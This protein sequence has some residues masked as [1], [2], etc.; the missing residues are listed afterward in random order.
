MAVL[1]T[2]RVKFGIAIT[3]IIALAL[4]SFIVDPNTL[5]S[6]SQAMS[7]KYDVGKING[8]TVSYQDF[9]ADVDTYTVISELMTGSS[10]RGDQ[11]TKEIRNQAWQALIDK[12]LFI[13]NA[14]A[15]GI[16]VGEQELIDLTTGANVSP[17]IAQNFMDEN[18]NFSKEYLVQFVQ[19]AKDDETG[20]LNTLWNYMQNVIRTQQYYTKY[21]ALFANSNVQSPLMLAKLIEE[22]NVSSNVDFVMVPTSF[23]ADSV[24]NVS[25]NEIK[26]YYNAHKDFFKQNA[27]RDIEYVLFQVTPSAKDVAE[28]KDAYLALYEEFTTTDNMKS[29]LLRNSD[30]P[31]S[32]YWYSAGELNTVNA[33]INEFVFSGAEGSSEMVQDG[34]TFYAARIMASKMIPDEIEVRYAPGSEMNDST[35]A[36]LRDAEPMTMTQSYMVP[37]F[38]PLFEAKVGTP[39]VVD[40]PSYGKF[41]AELVSSSE[42]VLK[43]QV[44]IY[45][46]AALPSKETY[47]NSYS[48][49]NALAVQSAGKLENFQAAVEEL[50]L[51]SHPVNRMTEASETLGGVE[52]TKEITRWAFDQKKAGKV[53]DIITIN[54][55]YFFVVACTGIH[56]EGYAPVEEAA[57]TIKSSLKADKVAEIQKA[58]IAK[59]I[60]GLNSLESIAEALGTTVSHSDDITFSSLM[61]Q[62]SDPAF[63]GAV[64]AAETGKI[65]GPVAGTYGV[66]VF[67]VNSR[68]T[69]SYFTEDDAK[70]S[71]MQLAQR[72]AQMLMYVM[73]DDADVKDNRARFF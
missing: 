15:A 61:S 59:K 25:S 71:E 51:V 27:S 20:R 10:V 37:G 21:A 70:A 32:N 7:S 53:S 4:L 49:A 8:K 46:K 58:E 45:E 19:S 12:Y 24:A 42:P 6:V 29:F 23:V 73:M 67:R 39:I 22:N 48:E 69:G 64:S 17:I 60:S 54:Q 40:V 68:E 57:A 11:E 3:V 41:L 55:N 2:I 44:A 50:G 63:V 28:A 38:E 65:T 13:K 14:N 31:L 35:L 36:V 62:G 72:N 9:Q 43:K 18:G 66:Y 26:N 47:N 30:R 33:A 52:N 56:K 1:E 5:S 16:E 34:D